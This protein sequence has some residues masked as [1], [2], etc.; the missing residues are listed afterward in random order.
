MQGAC[1]LEELVVRMCNL[2]ADA[3]ADDLHSIGEYDRVSCAVARLRSG[4]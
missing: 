3:E 1:T 2:L 4:W